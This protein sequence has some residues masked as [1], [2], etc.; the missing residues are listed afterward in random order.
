MNDQIFPFFHEDDPNLDLLALRREIVQVYLA[1][2]KMRPEE[3]RRHC[4][5]SAPNVSS[6]VRYND[7]SHW[8]ENMGRNRQCTVCKESTLNVGNVTKGCTTNVLTNIMDNKL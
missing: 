4:T 7:L 3:D 2:F 1:K 5:S 6:D 8:C